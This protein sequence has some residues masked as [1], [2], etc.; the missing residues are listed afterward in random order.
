[1]NRNRLTRKNKDRKTVK[2]HVIY[3][4]RIGWKAEDYPVNPE[5]QYPD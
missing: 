5:S 4:Q 3:P 1:M 2:K